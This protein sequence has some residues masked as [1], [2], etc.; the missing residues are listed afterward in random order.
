MEL[1]VREVG[2]VEESAAQVEEKLLKENEEKQT[3]QE[4]KSVEAATEPQQEAEAVPTEQKSLEEKD[5]LEYIRNRYDKPIESFD[6]LMAKREEK[7]ELPEDVAAYFKYKKETGR[8]INDYV[9][10]NRDFDEMNPDVLLTEYFLDSETAIDE[11]DVEALMDDYTFDADID[12]EKTI[13][14]IK[15][16]KKRKIVEAR[17]YF[18][19]QKDKYKQPLESSKEVLSN[20]AQQELDQYR[21][22]VDDAKTQAEQQKRKADW[23]AQKTEEVFSNEFKGFEFKVGEN[24]V[25]YNPGEATELK[26]SQGNIMNFVQKYL[27]EDGLM[28]DAPG[29]HKA[30]SLAMNPEK[31]AQ[32]FYEQGKTEAIES[33]ARKTK[34]INMK[35]RSA[36]EVVKQGGTQI[37]TVNNDSGNRLTIKSSRIR[38]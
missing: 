29:Y 7:E 34:N 6:D 16:A 38:K 33:D 30:L 35:L 36:P 28:K 32:F 11:E 14:K 3:I 1:K 26:K 5:V 25:M 24:S 2:K 23:F 21:Q 10:L 22:Y 37:R 8:G 27:G 15:L 19:E 9:K 12:D 31:F 4:E 18:N 17:K 13:K 20:D